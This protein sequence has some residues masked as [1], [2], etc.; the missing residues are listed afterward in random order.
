MISE[1]NLRDMVEADFVPILAAKLNDTDPIVAAQAIKTV[2]A[3]AED[4]EY[5]AHPDNMI[6]STD[7]A[8]EMTNALL[9]DGEFIPKILRI[10]DKEKE[11]SRTGAIRAIRRLSGNREYKPHYPL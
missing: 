5:P 10:L 1:R 8:K 11:G 3:I 7:L 6:Y 2:L 4:G 9:V